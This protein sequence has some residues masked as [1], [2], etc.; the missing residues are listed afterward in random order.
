M[1]RNKLADLRAL[2]EQPDWLDAQT[3]FPEDAEIAAAL[4]AP[5]LAASTVS[6]LE[7]HRERIAG[8]FDQ[9]VQGLCFSRHQYVEFV[10]DQTVAIWLGCHRRAFEWFNAVPR[11]LITDSAKCAIVKACIYD[12][13]VQRAY[14]GQPTRT[15]GD[16]TDRPGQGLPIAHRDKGDPQR[17]FNASGVALPSTLQA[18]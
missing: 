6:T 16:R 9:G 18:I 5:K 11:R 13:V 1:G 10:W 12:P 3:P 7:S 15:A 17:V 4:G 14:P 8:W 2:A